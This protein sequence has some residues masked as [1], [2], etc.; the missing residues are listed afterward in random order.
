MR[1]LY[2]PVALQA[3]DLDPALEEDLYQS[4]R[5][6]NPD[7]DPTCVDENAPPPWVEFYQKDDHR[8]LTGLLPALIGWGCSREQKIELLGWPEP[9]PQA[10][11]PPDLVP[12]TGRGAVDRWTVRTR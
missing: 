12:G 9:L 7:H 11:I 1:V 5:V 2:D 8:L 6:P 3:L 10:V 4:F